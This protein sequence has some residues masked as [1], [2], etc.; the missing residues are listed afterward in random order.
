MLTVASIH[1]HGPRILVRRYVRPDITP[2]GIVLPDAW[3]TDMSAELW[4]VV[5]AS[6]AAERECGH[7]LRADAIIKTPPMHAVPIGRVD[8]V[9]MFTVLA[10]HVVSYMEYASD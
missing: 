8:G 6:P 7:R 3:R 1:P 4:E 9:E 2:G 5:K 10:Q